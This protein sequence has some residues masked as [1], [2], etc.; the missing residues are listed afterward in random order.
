[1][2]ES[3]PDEASAPEAA[4]QNQNE[5]AIFEKVS[6][7]LERCRGEVSDAFEQYREGR[8]QDHNLFAR[9]MAELLQVDSKLVTARSCLY[10]A[11]M[12]LSTCCVILVVSTIGTAAIGNTIAQGPAV[13]SGFFA[14]VSFI[15]VR[16]F[17]ARRNAVESE[18]KRLNQ[19]HEKCREERRAAI[20]EG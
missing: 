6:D 2:P 15:A 19:E 5:S 7:A 20:K 14:V 1:M 18:M 8:R 12:A 13:T 4:E 17:A 16:K 3:H 10:F 11:K 9:Q